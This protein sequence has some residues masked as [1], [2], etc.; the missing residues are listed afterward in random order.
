MGEQP[1]GMRV[2]SARREDLPAVT[3]LL[4]V[5]GRPSPGAGQ[6]ERFR[7]VYEEQLGDPGTHHLVAEGDGELVGFCSLHFRGRLNQSQLEAWI[8]DLV[9]SPAT[10]RQG[11]AQ[12]LLE[13]AVLAARERDCHQLTLESGYARAEAHRLYERFGMTDTG[14]QFGMRLGD[15]D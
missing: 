13:V 5:L 2:R 14:K 4:E 11:V 15:A 6:E 12:V 1:H 3:A 8:P 9:V 10:R 7:A